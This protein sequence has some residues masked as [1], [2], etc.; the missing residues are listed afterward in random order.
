MSVCN[1]TQTSSSQSFN[2]QIFLQK[3]GKNGG[4]PSTT[5]LNLED[6]RK[7]EAFVAKRIGLWTNVLYEGSKGIEEYRLI[8]LKRNLYKDLPRSLEIGLQTDHNGAPITGADGKPIVRV[9]VLCKSKVSASEHSDPNISGVLPPHHTVKVD[10]VG[11]GSYKIAKAAFDWLTGEA[12]VQLLVYDGENAQG[13]SDAEVQTEFDIAKR[14]GARKGVAKP[15]FMRRRFVK[16]EREIGTNKNSNCQSNSYFMPR[17]RIDMYDTLRIIKKPFSFSNSLSMIDNLADSLVAYCD[18]GVIHRDGKLENSFQERDGTFVTADNGLAFTIEQYATCVEYKRIAC[19]TPAYVSP[20]VMNATALGRPTADYLTY[21][22]ARDMWSSGLQALS[23]LG[24]GHSDCE[25]VLT[26]FSESME[27]LQKQIMTAY[28][29]ISEGAV[30]DMERIKTYSAFC[31]QYANDNELWFFLS[32]ETIIGNMV[33]KE[34]VVDYAMIDKQVDGVL[35]RS[36]NI[37]R[38]NLLEVAFRKFEPLLWVVRMMLKANPK[39][40]ITPHALKKELASISA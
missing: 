40:R 3:I 12:F 1:T 24:A 27:L 29:L 25:D 26:R 38:I 5:G 35:L 14:L 36:L 30:T 16:V 15:G 33:K 22:Y 34:P 18:A 39:E 9:M 19:C 17:Y 21:P 32:F 37:I 31:T 7:I 2:E 28:Q 11:K 6:A 23:I 13:E 20:E 8:R 10:I 4:S